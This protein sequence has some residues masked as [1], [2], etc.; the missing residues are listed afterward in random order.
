[1][2]TVFFV[3]HPVTGKNMKIFF[4]KEDDRV[5]LV[6]RLLLNSYSEYMNKCWL[7]PT[8]ESKIK[9]T[10]DNCGDFLLAWN[11]DGHNILGYHKT[12]TI[13]NN[14]VLS[15]IDENMLE[16]SSK[17]ISSNLD[18]GDEYL[19]DGWNYPKKKKV[20]KK[21][22]GRKIQALFTIKSKSKVEYYKLTNK[23]LYDRNG[24]QY[25]EFEEIENLEYWLKSN[26]KNICNE[27]IWDFKTVETKEKKSV[28]D[29]DKPYVF[30][31]LPIDTENVFSYKGKLLKVSNKLEQYEVGEDNKCLMDTVGVIEQ[32]DKIYFI[33]QDINFITKY[34]SEVE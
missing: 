25:P 4:N 33:D 3:S 9:K 10:L 18:S 28:I 14:E 7:N 22:R 24:L 31:W 16:M 8:A 20:H 30:K 27:F 2:S 6:N 11:I 1:M 19:D 17:M 26:A 13:K 32:E 15:P 34:V 5:E 23:E 21:S 12:R 29:P